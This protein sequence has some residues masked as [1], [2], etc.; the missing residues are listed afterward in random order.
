MT[1]KFSTGFET[2]FA[3]TNGGYT[4]FSLRNEVT[5]TDID[6][7]NNGDGQIWRETSFPARSGIACCGT[8]TRGRMEFLF[9]EETMAQLGCQDQIYVSVWIHVP[10]GFKWGS[11][12]FLNQFG[13]G[14]LN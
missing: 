5:G 8:N 12:M 6:L 14:G 10:A 2:P 3:S 1:K 7:V 4:H 13:G 11:W 9:P